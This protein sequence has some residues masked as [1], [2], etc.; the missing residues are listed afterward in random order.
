MFDKYEYIKKLNKIK[1]MCESR[2][3][4]EDIEEDISFIIDNIIENSFDMYYFKDRFKNNSSSIDIIY[5]RIS[6]P[7]NRAFLKGPDHIRF[8]LSLYPYK[9]DLNNIAKIILRPKHFEIDNIELLALFIRRKKILV[10]YLHHPY[11]YNVN[12]SKFNEY[13]GFEPF[14]Y[15]ELACNK[16]SQ[17]SEKRLNNSDIKIF[18]LWYILSTIVDS[19]DRNIDKFFL[20]NNKKYGTTISQKLDDISSFHSKHGY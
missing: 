1:D 12:N 20:I 4:I 13:S 9:D 15:T 18:P 7:G 8:L 16:L 2:F 10:L 11:L 6:F 5:P 19:S 17:N 3:E 14:H